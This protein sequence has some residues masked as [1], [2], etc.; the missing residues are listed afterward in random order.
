MKRVFGIIFVV[1]IAACMGWTQ[2]APSDSAAATKEDIEKLF[3]TLHLREQ[4]QSMMAMSM[5]QGKQIA[6]DTIKKKDPQVTEADLR[7][8]DAFLDNFTKTIDMSG[9]LDDMIPV[10]QRHLT[11]QDVSAMLAFYDTTTGQKILREQPAMMAEAMQAMRPRMEKMM[12][13]ITDQ[14]EK[15]AKEDQKESTQPAKK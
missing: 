5:Q 1:L 13:D 11:K 10:Y 2:Q 9:M 7:R 3:D 12:R 6:H 14:A 8:M 15:M 4:M